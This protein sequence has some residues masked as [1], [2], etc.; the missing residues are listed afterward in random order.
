MLRDRPYFPALLIVAI[1]AAGMAAVQV[2]AVA[3]GKGVVY[4]SRNAFGSD[5][6]AFYD[7]TQKLRAGESPYQLP[8]Y[9]TPP[10]PAM[11]NYPLAL[12]PFGQAAW[13]VAALTIAAMLASYGLSTAALFR[14]GTADGKRVL[15]LGVAVLALSYPFYFLVVRGNI[16][17]FVLVLMCGGL[18]LSEK[19]PVLAGVCIALAAA[20]KVYPLLLLAPLL[21]RRKHRAAVS[22]VAVFAVLVA[23]APR[24]WLEAGSRLLWRASCFEMSENASIFCAFRFIGEAAR[25]LGLALGHGAWRW[26]ALVAFGALLL[27][28]LW[29]DWL[30]RGRR[31]PAEAQVLALM[32]F[33]FMVALPELTFHYSLVVLLPLIPA[34]AF[35]WGR[36]PGPRATR[37]LLLVAIGI[38]LSQSQAEAFARLAGNVVPHSL[39][40]LGLLATLVGCTWYK[41]RC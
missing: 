38:A 15:A 17:A 24:L 20:M 27:L 35:L 28:S 39:P 9:V 22:T 1:L 26:A 14:L 36:R 19:R 4:V 32:Y 37:I 41:V 18:C 11:A 6:Q 3:S 40:G 23:I 2:W 30:K 21:I 10:L 34:V 8:R 29:A 7:A 16:D 13:V 25:G 12:L 31:D 33:P 5:Y